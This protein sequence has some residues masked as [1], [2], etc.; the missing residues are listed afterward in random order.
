MWRRQNMLGELSFNKTLTVVIIIED[1]Y[2]LRG[3]TLVCGIGYS[4][5]AF[6]INISDAML[7]DARQETVRILRTFSEQL[8][9]ATVPRRLALEYSKGLYLTTFHRGPS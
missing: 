6:L 7:E 9:K 5:R 8:P 4:L 2:P 3:W 1:S